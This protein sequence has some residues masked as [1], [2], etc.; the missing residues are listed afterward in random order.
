MQGY[1]NSEDTDSIAVKCAQLGRLRKLLDTLIENDLGSNT[2][3]NNIRIIFAGSIKYRFFYLKS[4]WIENEDEHGNLDARKETV[5]D[6]IAESL[7]NNDSVKRRIV[8]SE[9]C[10]PYYV[11]YELLEVLK[12]GLAASAEI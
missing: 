6:T 9:E 5:S 1:A 2:H 12:Q 10:E 8:N 11:Y 3:T 7:L 4:R